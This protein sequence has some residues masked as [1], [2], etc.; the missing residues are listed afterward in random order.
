MLVGQEMQLEVSNQALSK[1]VFELSLE[2]VD[3]QIIEPLL[4]LVQFVCA[5]IFPSCPFVAVA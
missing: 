4:V 3:D 5:G 2:V 1:V